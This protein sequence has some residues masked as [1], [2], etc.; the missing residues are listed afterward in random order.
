MPDRAAPEPVTLIKFGGSFMTDA[1]GPDGLDLAVTRRLAQELAA[2]AT[3][4]LLVHGT[5]AVGKPAA[6]RHGFVD[7]G[8]VPAAKT[9]I[10]AEIRA[11]IAALNARVVATLRAAGIA[12]EGCGAARFFRDDCRTFHA[13]AAAELTAMLA[14]GTVPVLHGD[15]LRQADGSWQVFSS[16]VILERLAALLPVRLTLLLT[17]VDGVLDAQGRVIP[18]LSEASVDQVDRQASDDTDVSGGMRAKLRSAFAAAAHSQRCLI[19]NGA[20][21]GVLAAALRG[22]PVPGTR[23]RA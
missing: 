11:S 21:P 23:I 10:G 2:C 6:L 5:G 17:N 4:L 18:E 20:T 13:S 19:A 12:A 22:E 16:D 7:T 14:A 9:A 3:P 8:C 15:M 1:A